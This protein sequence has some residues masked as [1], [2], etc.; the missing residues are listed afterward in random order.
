[1]EETHLLNV[2]TS[3]SPGT[4]TTTPMEEKKNC[5]GEGERENQGK[6]G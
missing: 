4:K 3:A 2:V 5:R 6:A 1:M